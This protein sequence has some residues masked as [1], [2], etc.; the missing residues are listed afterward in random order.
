MSLRRPFVPP[1][2][3]RTNRLESKSQA[4][5]D[6]DVSSPITTVVANEEVGYDQTPVSEW[7][8]SDDE[9]DNV[10]ISNL[11]RA[12]KPQ[13]RGHRKDNS[14]WGKRMERQLG[15]IERRQEANEGVNIPHVIPFIPGVPMMS[16]R[17]ATKCAQFGEVLR[18]SED[19]DKIPELFVKGHVNL[20]KSVAKFFETVLFIGTV[21]EIIPRRTDFYY[22]VTYEDGDQE[23]MDNEELMYALELKYKK[24][25]GEDLGV[26]A[27]GVSDLSGLS[28]EGSE[29]DSEEDKRE[30]R[31]NKKRKAAE[32]K[33]AKASNSKKTK[34]N[35]VDCSPRR[36]CKHWW[37]RFNA[38]EIHGKVTT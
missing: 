38:R 24:D 29:Y 22:K 11:L 7:A 35:E 17:E 6:V 23:D 33:A 12:D 8:V 36:C 9:D 21:T 4:E 32:E 34:K 1:R 5:K 14:E 18:W 26:E 37:S 27:E 3:T 25:K 16:E 2:S 20:G 10:P 15:Q 28:E 13:A 30:A 19:E 31:K